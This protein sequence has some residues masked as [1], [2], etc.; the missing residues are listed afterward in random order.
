MKKKF[1]VITL[2]IILV[3]ALF[4]INMFWGNPISRT[5]AQKETIQYYENA[6]KEKFMIYDSEYNFLIP[7]YIFEMGPVNNKNIKFDTSLFC[8]GITDEY[9]G[10]LASIK[11]S[12][13]IGT[14]LQTEYR[15]LNYEISAAEE[16]LASYAGE[17]ADYF[18]T[19]PSKRVLRN[20]YNLVIT[21]PDGTVSPEKLTELAPDMAKRIESKIPYQT[22]NLRVYIKLESEQLFG[23]S[24]KKE[25]RKFFELFS[26]TT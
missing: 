14:I 11:L 19:D 18:E 24:D 22:P 1:L 5:I 2:V 13:D 23:E 26:T 16:P 6:Y 7:A 20:H 10:I 8:Q 15:Y 3:V 21:V 9:G 12:Q 4:L 17:S 25:G